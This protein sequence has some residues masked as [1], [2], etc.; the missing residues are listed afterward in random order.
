VKQDHKIDAALAFAL[1]ALF[2]CQRKRDAAYAKHFK[3]LY[4]LVAG[5]LILNLFMLVQSFY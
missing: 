2:L 4:F 3:R 1:A 5:L